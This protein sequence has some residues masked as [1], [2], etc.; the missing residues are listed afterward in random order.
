MNDDKVC[1]QLKQDPGFPLSWL[2]RLNDR[3]LEH[4]DSNSKEHIV[5]TVTILE[6]GALGLPSKK[7]TFAVLSTERVAFCFFSCPQAIFFTFSV[8]SQQWRSLY[9]AVHSFTGLLSV[10]TPMI[11]IHYAR[12]FSLDFQHE[13]YK[14]LPHE[15]CH[16][17]NT[18][19]PWHFF[20]KIKWSTLLLL[21]QSHGKS[22]DTLKCWSFCQTI[23][24]IICV[25]SA[26]TVLPFCRNFL[27]LDFIAFLFFGVLTRISHKCRQ[28]VTALLFH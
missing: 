21:S 22:L 23:T 2:Q 25:L 11:L 1:H 27:I 10:Q 7:V 26:N 18:R 13:S 5:S 14:R 19:P 6:Q 17:L 20:Y 12:H 3:H 8:L 28:H 4:C 9:L 15:A 16:N 24:H